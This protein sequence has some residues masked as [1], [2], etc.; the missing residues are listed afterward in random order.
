MRRLVLVCLMAAVASQAAGCIIS[1]DDDT[2]PP[3]GDIGF[4]D[5]SWSFGQV[6]GATLSCPPGVDI[7][8]SARGVENIDDI[9]TCSDLQGTS[10]DGHVIGAYDV[11][12]IAGEIDQNGNVTNEYGRSPT[13]AVDLVPAD[14]A[15]SERFIDDGGR[16]IFN[17]NLFA[18]GTNNALTC[19]SGGVDGVAIDLTLSGSTQLVSE[20]F[21]CEDVT[22]GAG[23]AEDLVVNGVDVAAV[24]T[25]P[26]LAGSY[27]ASVSALDAAGNSISPA[28]T[29]ENVLVTAPNGY[30]DLT[31]VDIDVQ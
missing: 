14:V 31:G 26:L 18:A 5:A 30:A 19:A 29:N 3:G 24:R 11:E 16:I 28:P 23:L 1:S 21:N 12:I 6:S 25:D 10:I 17:A 9:F 22:E 7:K 13:Y 20:L 15:V 2:P 4:I 27:V 8:V